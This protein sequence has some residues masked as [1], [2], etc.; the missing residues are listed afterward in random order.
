MS[1]GAARAVTLKQFP[2]IKKLRINS[3]ARSVE[4]WACPILKTQNK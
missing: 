4:L 2:V 1:C 3:L